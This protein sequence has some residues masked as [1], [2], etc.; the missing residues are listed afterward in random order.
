MPRKTNIDASL[1]ILTTEERMLK[2]GLWPE[3]FET[4]YQIGPGL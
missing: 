2:Y 4:A 3:E 1:F